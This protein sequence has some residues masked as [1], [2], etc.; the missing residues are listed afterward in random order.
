MEKLVVHELMHVRLNQLL[1]VSFKRKQY[2][3]IVQGE[4]HD[5]IVVFEEVLVGMSRK[6]AERDEE[7]AKLRKQVDELKKGSHVVHTA[8]SEGS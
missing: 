5:V 4:E 7:I 1:D 8:Q 3:E 6:I 2:D